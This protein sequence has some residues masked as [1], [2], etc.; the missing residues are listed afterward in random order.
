MRK[1]PRRERMEPE[2]ELSHKMIM[3]KECYDGIY[4]HRISGNFALNV[5]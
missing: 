3:R 5:K 1:G 4:L 2:L